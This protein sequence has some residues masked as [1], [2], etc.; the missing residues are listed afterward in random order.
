MKVHK[1][2]QHSTTLLHNFSQVYATSQKT[3]HNFTTPYIILRSITQ[4][5]LQTLYTTFFV[6][7]F[8][9]LNKLFTFYKLYKTVHNLTQLYTKTNSTK[10]SQQKN[11]KTLQDYTQLYKVIQKYITL[12]Y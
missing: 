5:F 9:K 11:H 10:R 3:L 2:I 7:D 12:F 6:Q 4:L 1:T 8:T